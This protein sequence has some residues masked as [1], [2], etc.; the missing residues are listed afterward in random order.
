VAFGTQL[1]RDGDVHMGLYC[2]KTSAAVSTATA[3]AVIDM[4]YVERYKPG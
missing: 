4:G 1:G 3:L 2:I